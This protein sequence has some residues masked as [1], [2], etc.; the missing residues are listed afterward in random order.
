MARTIIVTGVTTA[1]GAAFGPVQIH[2]AGP[3]SRTAGAVKAV[4]RGVDCAA[5]AE[6]VIE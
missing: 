1:G 5:T 2:G 6:T 4:D 3:Y